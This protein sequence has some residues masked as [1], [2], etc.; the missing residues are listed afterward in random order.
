MAHRIARLVDT[1]KALDRD[2]AT[3]RLLETLMGDVTAALDSKEKLILVI[4]DYDHFKTQ[5]LEAVRH[6]ERPHGPPVEATPQPKM[7]TANK[8]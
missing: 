7:E 8:K 4:N 3:Q 2:A 5:L 1:L 6:V